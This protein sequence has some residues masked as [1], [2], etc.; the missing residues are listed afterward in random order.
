MMARTGRHSVDLHLNIH[1][2]LNQ[3]F[4][5]NHVKNCIVFKLGVSL[6]H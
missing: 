3:Y 4:P 2:P 6:G 1:T 5:H